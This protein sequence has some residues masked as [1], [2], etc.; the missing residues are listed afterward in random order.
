MADFWAWVLGGR[1]G[2]VG[3]FFWKKRGTDGGEGRRQGVLPLGALLSQALWAGAP[4]GRRTICVGHARTH[5]LRSGGAADFKA[6]AGRHA[7]AP[8]LVRSLPMG[9]SKAV[10]I[11]YVNA[12]KFQN[13]ASFACI[14]I[15]FAFIHFAERKAWCDDWL[16][17]I[18]ES[19]SL[20]SLQVK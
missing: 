10:A 1:R 13:R 3:G 12:V 9:P 6:L 5:E 17:V 14:R 18:E 19:A 2:G 15:C 7:A 20:N 8:K 11:R 4:S 16:Q